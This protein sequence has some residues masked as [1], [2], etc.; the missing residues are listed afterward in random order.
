MEIKINIGREVEG[1]G[2]LLVPAECKKVSRRHASLLWND[3]AVTLEDNE[4][5]NGTFVNGKRIAKTKISETDTV[6]LGGREGEP[7]SYTLDLKKIFDSCHQ[8]EKAQRTD[9]SRE[10]ED[11]KQAYVNYQAAVA[12]LKKG[13]AV[14]SQMPL[15]II[16]F[17]PTL[18]GAV[19]ALL[20]DA[21]PNARI[22]AISVGGAI[23]GLIN[24]LMTGRNSN[25]N[26]Q[27]TE[28]IT[29]LQIQYQPRYSCP[30]CGTKFP[31]TTHWKKL[32]ADGKCPN[33][34]CNAQFVKK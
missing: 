16:S 33:P 22:V 3:G 30:K 19:I 27:I 12:Q 5:S 15:R 4:S 13:I 2:S 11:V 17:V 29:E 20:P 1:T 26:D 25:A 8:A 7:E 9:Y 32:Q 34:K 14:K 18:I 31:F 21:D 6:S 10:F 23:T 24:I 28:E